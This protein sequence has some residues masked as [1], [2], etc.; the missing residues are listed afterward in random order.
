M[1][2]EQNEFYDKMMSDERFTELELQ[3]RYEL[4]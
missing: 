2:K 4:E 1:R 3:M